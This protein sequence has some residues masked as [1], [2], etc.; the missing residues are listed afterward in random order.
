MGAMTEENLILR[1][2]STTDVT[3][4]RLINFYH[5]LSSTTPIAKVQEHINFPTACPR[6]EYIVGKPDI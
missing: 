6:I 2:A 1:R 4:L 5:L 3:H